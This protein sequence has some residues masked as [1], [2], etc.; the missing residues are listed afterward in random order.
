MPAKSDRWIRKMSLEHGMIE[1]FAENQVRKG[2]ISYG[3]SSYGYD[4]RLHDEFRIFKKGKT[5][6]IDPKNFNS[7]LLEIHKGSF[8]IVPPNSLIV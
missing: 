7:E 8:C 2:V 1:P 4:M 6:E 3:V 5:G